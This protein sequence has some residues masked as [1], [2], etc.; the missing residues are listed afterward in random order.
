MAVTVVGLPERPNA[1]LLL[2]DLYTFT[3]WED[4]MLAVMERSAM[5]QDFRI[6]IDRRSAAPPTSNFVACMVNFF[7]VHEA[8]LS[9]TRAAVLVSR[10]V[11]E[12][13][14]DLRV[15]RFRI[16]AFNDAADAAEWLHPDADESADRLRETVASLSKG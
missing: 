8:R 3:E 16:R 9:G 1:E 11:P 15:G 12:A 10:S 4:A 14:P 2:I 6:L 7:R 13:L 5:P